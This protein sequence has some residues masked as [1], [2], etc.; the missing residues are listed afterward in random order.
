MKI[1]KSTASSDVNEK[2]TNNNIENTA[3]N[4]EIWNKK[5]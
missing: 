2:N 1:E 4:A 5:N 3:N